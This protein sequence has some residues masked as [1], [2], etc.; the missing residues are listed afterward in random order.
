[1][2]VAISELIEDDKKL[3]QWLRDNSS[4][5]YKASALAAD[6]I[7]SLIQEGMEKE[8]IIERLMGSKS[9]KNMSPT[10]PAL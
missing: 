8:K 10:I 4:G 2:S 3:C 6:R 1:M 7:E 9:V 5:S